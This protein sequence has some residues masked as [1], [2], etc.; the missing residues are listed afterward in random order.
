MENNLIQ[1]IE[2]QEV[3]RSIF[4]NQW[5]KTQEVENT[6]SMKVGKDVEVWITLNDFYPLQKPPSYELWAPNLS[7]ND[8]DFVDR[9]FEA[10]FESNKGFPI[11]FQWIEKLK[12]IV[13]AKDK[14]RAI[15]TKTENRFS[16][17]Q[18]KLSENRKSV[19]GKWKT[20]QKPTSRKHLEKE[21]WEITHGPAISDRKSTFQAHVC[22]VTDIS[23]I[24]E[25][26]EKLLENRKIAQAKHNIV[27]Y[28]IATDKNNLLQNSEDDGE[29]HAG[30]KLLYSLDVLGVRNVVVVVSRWYGGIQLGQD[31]FRHYNNAARQAL[32][33]AGIIG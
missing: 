23:Q 33:E 2:E 1:Q 19:V 18:K 7:K 5:R 32:A 8:K 25:F 22:R 20:A 4:W 17:E 14:L 24:N 28:R 26:K 31:R 15:K 21:K 30:G 27:A 6:Y 3:L 10:I 13:E 9:E 16:V 11:I 12:E 29:A